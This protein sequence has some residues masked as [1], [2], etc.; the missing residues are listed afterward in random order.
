M[1]LITEN[2][3]SDKIIIPDRKILSAEDGDLLS[4]EAFYPAGYSIINIFDPV[5]FNAAKKQFTQVILNEL[6]KNNVP[7]GDDF[8]LEKY[9]LYVTDDHIHRKIAKWSMPLNVLEEPSAKVVES[10]NAYLNKSLKIKPISENSAKEEVL[11]GFRLIRPKS[12]DAAP[13]HKDAWLDMWRRVV[14]VWIPLAG[15]NQQS[16]LG[17]IPGSHL[18][19][20]DEITRTDGGGTVNNKTYKVPVAVSTKRAFTKVY[21]EVKEGDA[22]LFSPYLLHGGGENN[23]YDITRVSIEYRLSL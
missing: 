19:Y 6:K 5:N 18:W 13:F 20:E 7:A 15:C 22:I 10:V 2:V 11:F 14:N 12:N 23:N 9:H 3:K 16:T 4:N 8:S 21:P 17:L 1:N